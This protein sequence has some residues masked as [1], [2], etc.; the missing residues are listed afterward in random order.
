MRLTAG[1]R[2][3]ALSWLLGLL[4]IAGCGGGQS[5]PSPGRHQAARRGRAH[6]RL[7]LTA[8]SPVPAQGTMVRGAAARRAAVPVLMYHVIKAPP[9]G[10]RYPELWV[11]PERFAAEMTA[12]RDDGYQGVTLLQVLNAWRTGTAL[13]RRPVVV[14]FDDGYPS[15][16]RGAFPILRHFGW[17]GVLNL[18]VHNLGPAGIGVGAVRRLLAAGW[19]VDSHTVTHPDLTTVDDTRLRAELVTSRRL[20]RRRLGPGV[21]TLFCYPSGRYD[22]RVEAA[23]R[24]AGYRAATTTQPGW[25]T[26][27]VDRFALPRVRVDGSDDAAT[28]LAAVRRAEP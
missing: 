4:A 2:R 25:A 14:S 11:A 5:A 19:E 9:P 27:A 8:A 20:L 26:P 3:L 15:Q 18:E 22:A 7:V 1:V 6:H 10:T 13:P 24:A 21:A 16:E 17:P 12:L 28:V 23:V